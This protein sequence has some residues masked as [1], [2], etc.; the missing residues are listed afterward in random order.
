MIIIRFIIFIFFI[1]IVVVVAVALF[2][3]HSSK[4]MEMEKLKYI[5]HIGEDFVMKLLLGK[6]SNSCGIFKIEFIIGK[7]G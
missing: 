4:T 6:H 5:S 2:L 1:F 7:Y 3:V